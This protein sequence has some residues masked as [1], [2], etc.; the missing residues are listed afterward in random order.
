MTLLPNK[1]QQEN[2]MSVAIVHKKKY[3]RAPAT[4]QCKCIKRS[5]ILLYSVPDSYM[6]VINFIVIKSIY[7]P[8]TEKLSYD[9]D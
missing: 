8:F 5:I 1:K 2:I 9:W 7:Y 6:P 3:G 4:I